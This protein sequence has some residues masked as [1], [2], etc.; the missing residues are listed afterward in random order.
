MAY[1]IKSGVIEIFLT[2]D[3]QDLPLVLRG[4]G[5]LVGE[6][7]IIDQRPRSASA[8]VIEDCEL[9]MIT[10]EQVS[11]R[12]ANTDP[13]LRMCLGVVIERYRETVAM[14]ARGGSGAPSGTAKPMATS[15]EFEKAIRTLSLENELRRA[16]ANNEFEIYFQPIVQLPL[17][18]LAGYEALIRWNHPE[19][20]IVSP[21]EF[22]PVAEACGLITDI[23]SWCIEEIGRQFPRIQ[24]SAFGNVGL[25]EPLFLS[26]NISGHDLAHEA[27]TGKLSAMMKATGLR[28]EALKLEVTES[29]LMKEPIKAAAVLAQ[30][31]DLGLRIAIDDFGTGYSS[32]SHLSTLPITTIK[33]D[34]SFV[35]SM[36]LD[37]TSRKIIQMILRLA[38]ELDIPVIAEGIEGEHEAGELCRLGCAFGQGYLFGRPQPISVTLPLTREWR[39]ADAAVPRLW[40]ATPDAL[41]A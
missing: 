16:L 32:L 25:R 38:G 40:I 13:I 12:I 27:F 18:Q 34:Q 10:E 33:I 28:P 7:A 22:I 19:R 1:L 3:G 5:D 14:I 39:A 26:L 41:C 36:I 6:M 4:P 2:R 15:A 35:R 29:V 30:C 37:P 23:T 17:R 11:H 24:A 21:G 9:S 20:G 8:R 31:R